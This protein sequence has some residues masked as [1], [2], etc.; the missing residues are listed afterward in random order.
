MKALYFYFVVLYHFF[1]LYHN[2]I[3]KKTDYQHVVSKVKIWPH[4]VNVDIRKL[5]EFNERTKFS[6]IFIL[7]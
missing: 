4:L 5:L 3:L 2:L 6:A 7:T 1:M